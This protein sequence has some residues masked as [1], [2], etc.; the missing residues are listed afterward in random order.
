V[1]Y[2]ENIMKMKRTI[3]EKRR[4]RGMSRRRDGDRGAMSNGDMIVN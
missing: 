1:R 3:G 2:N 4:K